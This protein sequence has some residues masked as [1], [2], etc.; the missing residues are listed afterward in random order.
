MQTRLIIA[1]VALA[2][3]ARA[4]EPSIRNI[5]LRGLQVGGTTTIVVDGDDLGAA[6]KLLLPFLAQQ[7]L[8]PGGADNQATFVVQLA[9]DVTPGFHQLRVVTEGGASLPVVVSVDKLPQQLLAP[10]VDQVPVALH[11]NVGGSS[12]AET[13][14]AGKA[15]QKLLFEVEALR[16][17]SKL[18]PVLHLYDASRKQI[19]WSWPLTTH[20][21]DTMLEATLPADGQYTIALHDVEYAPPGP[22]FFR[23]K[24]GEWSSVEQVFPPAIAKGRPISLELLGRGA[25]SK[26]DLPPEAQ[27]GPWPLTLPPEATW[28]GNRPFITISGANEALEQP[29]AAAAQEF[30]SLPA[31][32]S[33][34]L[35]T[36]FEE[37]RYQLHVTPGTR[38][39]FEAFAERI[40]SPLDT[41]LIVRNEKGDILARGEDA[42]GMVDPM[43]DFVVP[44]G[45]TLIHVCIVDTQGRGSPRGIYRLEAEQISPG[46]PPVDFSLSTAVQRVTVA[47][48]GKVIL[49]IFVERRGYDGPIDLASALPGGMQLTN[50]QIRAESDGVLLVIERS[51]AA[52]DAI[53]TSFRGKSAS[54]EVRPVTI[55]GHPLLKQQPWLASE[56]AIAPTS[57]KATELS[58]DWRGL[59]D[60]ASLSPGGRLALPVAVERNVEKSLV[61]LT[62]L[63]N[64]FSPLVNNQ[65]DLNRT[66]RAEKPVELAAEAKEGEVTLL[67]PAELPCLDYEVTVQAELLTA[68]RKTVIATAYAPVRRMA[69]KHQVAIQ[70]AT[71]RLEA[72]IDSAKGAMLKLEGKIERRNGWTGDVTIAVAGLPPGVPA[73]A[74]TVKTDAVDFALNFALPANLAPGDYYGIELSA[75]GPLD[76]KQ[77]NIRIKSRDAGL[78]LAV[79]RVAAPA[80]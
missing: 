28:S 45:V 67:I 14:F 48:G 8:K 76:T 15:G 49:P 75:S 27:V 73:P 41:A 29:P 78:V 72:S 38:L 30:P 40:G 53:V 43:L 71:P 12:I 9:A 21:G 46:A 58:I 56:I 52:S 20:S 74:A 47:P 64:Q 23:L 25:P 7:E 34:R 32:V 60:D 5:H 51:D 33:G 16:L 2:P 69:V 65:P 77:P 79:Q 24:I 57:T 62:L 17:G 13:K 55:K 61:R 18:R 66:L 63:T 22:G 10:V 39:R 59:P 37:D 1:L 11:G 31:G 80:P 54:G 44:A 70:L 68:D 3:L 36:P 42:P 26:L 19:A 35:A 6:P 4:T 50:A